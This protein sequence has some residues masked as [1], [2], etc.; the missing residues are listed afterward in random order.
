MH[1]YRI[2]LAMG[3]LV[4]ASSIWAQNGAPPQQAPA[5]AEGQSQ[6][7]MLKPD[8]MIAELDTNHDGCVSKQEWTSAG[9]PEAIYNTLEGQAAKRDCVTAAEF[10]KGPAP[11]GIDTDGDGYLSVQELKAY[12]KNHGTEPR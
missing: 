6:G 12:V 11:A 4:F 3:S 10:T 2:M 7:V 1:P 9:L 5:A 8:K